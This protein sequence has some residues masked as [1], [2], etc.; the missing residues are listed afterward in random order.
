MLRPRLLLVGLFSLLVCGICHAQVTVTPMG[1]MPLPPPTAGEQPPK[2]D[3]ETEK[4][5]LDLVETLAEQVLNLRS[6]ANRIRAEVQVADLLWAR[7]EKRARTLFTAAVSQLTTQ[8][9]ELDYG[10]P[11]VYNEMTRINNSRQELVLRIAPHDGDMAIDALARTRFQG[12]NRT[13]YGGNW[14]ASS[15]ANLEMMLANVIA[16]KN[17]EAALK[18]ARGSLSRGVSGSLLSFLPLL[19]QK[20]AKSAQVFYQEIV[21]R[22]K[23][24]NP[25]R[26]PE[27]A[28]N[29]WNLLTSFQPPQAGEDAYRDLLTT[30][31]GN[32]LSINRQ[33]QQGMNQAQNMFYQ[34]E[35][36]VPLIEKY[37]PARAA[38]LREW[39]RGIE[40][41]VDPNTQIYQEI[42]RVSEKGTAD[43]IMALAAKYP[44]EYQNLLYQNAAWKAVSSGDTAHAK[45]IAEKIADPVQRRQ[46]IDQ[47]DNQ[48]ARAAEGDN[49][50]IEARR[51]S[52]KA[53]TIN[54]KIE[55][56]LQ[57]AMALS[58]NDKK[59][60]L[61]LLSEA[62][63]VLASSPQSAAELNAQ[64]Q[65]IQVYLRLDPEQAFGQLQP[66][67][68]RLNE[69]VAAAVIL[70]GIDYRYLKDGEWVMQQGGNALS[71]LVTSLDRMLATLGRVDFDRARTLADQI[72]R[73]EMRVMME[74]DLVQMTLSGKPGSAPPIFFG[75]RTFS[76]GGFINQ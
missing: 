33:T 9:S 61:D 66:L 52:E 24:D 48:A 16:A 23:D 37:A 70:D 17:P 63:S 54:R 8:I 1:T 12:D 67:V 31:L 35:R 38:E 18:L 27:L 60:A 73:P 55:I 59:A 44:P 11:E 49:K 36:I 22:I 69:L 10:D 76:S 2:L 64:M 4:K 6:S 75:G 71:N 15:E 7:D 14:T 13:R 47:L 21:A 46:V 62:K 68:V 5:A 39:S 74:I 25:A 40:K 57:S 34:I 26:N 58:P 72:G 20:D 29:A 45:E 32:L 42:R 50:V 51:L 3:P 53:S 41:T 28:N 30:M 56:L 19:Y 65:L 43:D